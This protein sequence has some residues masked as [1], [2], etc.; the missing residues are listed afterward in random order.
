MIDCYNGKFLLP[1]DTLESESQNKHFHKSGKYEIKRVFIKDKKIY[2]TV[3]DKYGV[4]VPESAGRF[5]PTAKTA[6][7]MY[8]RNIIAIVD[9]AW[10]TEKPI[11]T[12]FRERS[13]K[14][15]LTTRAHFSG[16]SKAIG[17]VRWEGQTKYFESKEEA[18]KFFFDLKTESAS[19]LRYNDQYDGYGHLAII[20]FMITHVFPAYTTDLPYHK[21]EYYEWLKLSK[22][23]F[24]EYFR[25]M[26]FDNKQTQDVVKKVITDISTLYT[27]IP[28]SYSATAVTKILLGK[29]KVNLTKAEP[30]NGIMTGM[31]TYDVLFEL[32]QKIDTYLHHVKIFTTKE[33][34]GSGDEWRGDFEFIGSK[35]IDKKKLETFL[36]F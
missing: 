32:V 35:A 15:E 3:L 25:D 31:L 2:V 23:E 7:Q 4:E 18:Y 22:E 26:F 13:T 6:T 16:N 34:Y 28:P 8:K 21:E 10:D 12:G 20:M 24:V 29:G 11:F 27:L 5:K 14:Y 33:D 30:Y 1:G 17:C 19:D 9:L 36:E